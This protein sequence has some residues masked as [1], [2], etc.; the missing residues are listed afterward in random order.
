MNEV[1]N[2]IKGKIGLKAEC[3]LE[4]D[5]E[6]QLVWDALERVEKY[7]WHDLRKN[8]EDLP[9]DDN[10]EF[11]VCA[12]YDNGIRC[13]TLGCFMGNEGMVLPELGNW[14]RNKYH[15]IAWRYIEPFEE[16]NE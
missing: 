12:E 16:D 8:P 4:T 9:Y 11:I 10:T 13:V 7:A 6:R 3:I 5:E 14:M 15:I 2:I 1:L